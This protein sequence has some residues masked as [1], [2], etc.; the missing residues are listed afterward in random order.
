ME[1]FLFKPSFY[2]VCVGR[3]IRFS[4]LIW[5]SPLNQCYYCVEAMEQ[6]RTPIIALGFSLN[7]SLHLLMIS[8]FF[9]AC[10][11]PLTFCVFTSN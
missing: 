10:T 11:I 4:T 5:Y 8:F 7:I 2:Y 3:W 6:I 9:A 1:F